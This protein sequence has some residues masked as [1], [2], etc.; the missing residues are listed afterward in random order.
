MAEEGLNAG[1]DSRG[2]NTSSDGDGL[3]SGGGIR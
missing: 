3:T 1:G 2:I